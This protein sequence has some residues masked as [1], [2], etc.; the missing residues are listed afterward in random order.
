MLLAAAG[1]HAQIPNTPAAL[2]LRI[3][4]GL[5]GLNQ[6]TRNEE[7][8]WSRELVRL[9]GG[10][11]S[12]EIVPFDRAGVP[13]GD[14]LRLLQLGVMPFGTTL[15][16]AL[17]QQSPQYAGI[18]LAGLNPNM[19]ALKKNVAAFRPFLEKELR[20]RHNVEMLAL[21]VYPAQVIFCNR[22]FSGL[23][24]LAGRHVRVSSSTQADFI[25]ALG[26]I[27][28]AT[29]FAQ[30][31]A[32][33]RSGNTDCAITGTMSGHT[34][35]LHQVTSHVHSMPI[36]WGLAVFGANKTAW[37]ALPPDLKA[38]LRRE[39]PKLETAI[40]VE[41]ER[42]SSEGLACNTGSS[43]CKDAVRG[44]LLQVPA[45]AKDERLRQQVFDAV[46]LPRWLARCGTA[47]TDIWRQ[48]IGA[49]LTTAVPQKP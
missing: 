16:S 27:P 13:G 39:L 46:V 43:P 15:I 36:T 34:L 9:S 32:N 30:I 45:T 25:A 8:F 17:A 21:Y 23:A 1:V 29:G 2:H 18:D 19:T 6:Y 26:A 35:G 38:L 33:M 12:A 10:K 11:Y 37:D 14:M 20:Q 28:V 22:P 40:W 31:I 7:P 3:V 44:E 24:D 4:G 42:E 5:A 48:T 47:C 41:S 49:H